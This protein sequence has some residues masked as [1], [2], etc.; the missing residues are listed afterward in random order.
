MLEKADVGRFMVSASF[1]SG[2]RF[3]NENLRKAKEL[4]NCIRFVN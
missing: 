3:F 2:V 1:N 4:F